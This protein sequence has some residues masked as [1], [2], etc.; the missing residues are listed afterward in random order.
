MNDSLNLHSTHNIQ[1]HRK[2][3]TI[4]YIVFEMSMSYVLLIVCHYVVLLPTVL[5][6]F[7]F[8]SPVLINK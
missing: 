2:A 8:F 1:W 3:Y 4:G 6:A 5:E 7:W